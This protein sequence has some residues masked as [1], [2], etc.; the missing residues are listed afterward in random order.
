MP[1]VRMGGPAAGSQQPEVAA[2]LTAID[3][4]ASCPICHFLLDTP[5]LLRSCGHSCELEGMVALCRPHS[6]FT[7]LLPR[8]CCQ[9]NACWLP[10]SCRLQHLHP[11]KPGFPRALGAAHLPHVSVSMSRMGCHVEQM[12]VCQTSCLLLSCQ[13]YGRG[14]P[15]SK[16]CDARDLLPNATLREILDKYAAARPLLLAG[17]KESTQAVPGQGDSDGRQQG[18]AV[19]RWSGRKRMRMQQHKHE[20]EQLHLDK[21]KIDQQA[22]VLPGRRRTRSASCG[23]VDT[24]LAERSSSGWSDDDA[25]EPEVSSGEA[26]DDGNSSPSPQSQRLPP[27]RHRQMP[28]ASYQQQQQ[29]QQHAGQQAEGRPADTP[30]GFVR[31]P[32]CR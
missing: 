16:P 11:P 26:D 31:C 5:L 9:V 25:S 24:D 27:S 6:P 13:P 32:V 17:A 19:Q 18:Q 28:P 20:H 2:A 29:Q 7:N 22:G 12:P 14:L 1:A 21:E 8:S 10:A 4:A 15:C 3:T 30:S 23:K